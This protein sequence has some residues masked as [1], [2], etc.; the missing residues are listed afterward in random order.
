MTDLKLSNFMDFFVV[1][2]VVVGRLQ[3]HRLEGVQNRLIGMQFLLEL[4]SLFTNK[5]RADLCIERLEHLYREL[6]NL[7]TNKNVPTFLPNILQHILST[8]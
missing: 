8:T 1:V 6:S 2:V 7:F 5:K 3:C 4:S